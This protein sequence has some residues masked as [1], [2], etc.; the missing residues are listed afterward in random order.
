M[1][2]ACTNCGGSTLTEQ[3]RRSRDKGESWVTVSV[4][5][6]L[7]NR[8]KNRC[9]VVEAEPGKE[10]VAKTPA[11][12]RLPPRRKTLSELKRMKGNPDL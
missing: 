5:R 6:C 11:P 2:T 8:L 10:P 3:V 9:P 1:S 7:S 4:T 12:V